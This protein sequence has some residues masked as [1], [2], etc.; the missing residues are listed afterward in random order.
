ME[1]TDRLSLPL[2]MPGQ[3]QKEVWHNEAL[4]ILDVLVGGA[5]EDGPS[6][7]PPASPVAG[8][9]Y[10]IGN[11]PTGDWSGFANAVAA[12]GNSGWRFLAPVDG[13]QLFVKSPG[14]VA[15]YR[16]G[17]WETG[18]LRGTSLVIDGL[19]VVGARGGAVAD[20]SGGAVVDAEARLAIGQM[21]A[22]LRQHGL[23]SS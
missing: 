11:S 4:E 9:A 5:V 14:T 18:I 20:P 2:L 21:L 1:S 17:A 7:D 10:L 22:V 6:N 16:S 13:M 15:L 3:A 8:N 23:I 12:Y 19:Q